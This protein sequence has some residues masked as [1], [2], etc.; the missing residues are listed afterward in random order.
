[1]SNAQ[2]TLIQPIVNLNKLYSY[3][4]NSLNILSHNFKLFSNYCLIQQN[5]NGILSYAYFW[6]NILLL[7]LI[8]KSSFKSVIPFLFVKKATFLNPRHTLSS[9]LKQ[10]KLSYKRN[11]VKTSGT[12]LLSQMYYTYNSQFLLYKQYF[13]NISV[14]LF[15]PF[16]KKKPR[17]FTF[18]SK[19]FSTKL[20]KTKRLRKNIFFHRKF[21][22]LSILTQ[23]NKKFKIFNNNRFNSVRKFLKT[24][25]LKKKQLLKKKHYLTPRQT[26]FLNGRRLNLKNKKA[27]KT[28]LLRRMVKFYRR[29]L[30]R[31]NLMNFHSNSLN[32]NLKYKFKLIKSKKR[33]YQM[34]I[35]SLKSPQFQLSKLNMQRVIR[36]GKSRLK[37]RRTKKY[38]SLFLKT[39][40]TLL[41]QPLFTSLCRYYKISRV[42][43]L[44]R[45][46]RRH[47][48]RYKLHLFPSLFCIPNTS[49]TL[50]STTN[51]MDGNED[52][53]LITN[54]FYS[55]TSSRTYYAL[56]K[57][58]SKLINYSF[59]R[60]F[61]NLF[62][63][64]VNPQ[65]SKN[66]SSLLIQSKYKTPFI[67][68]NVGF[69][70]I[71]AIFI[72]TNSYIKSRLN[73]FRYS[74]FFKKDL[75][76]YLLRKPGKLKLISTSILSTNYRKKN[77]RFN[78]SFV[79]NQFTNKLFG[80]TKTD[81][82]FNLTNLLTSQNPNFSFKHS[83]KYTK[84]LG[85]FFK[86][87]V[88][89]KRI[90]FKPGYA[91]IWRNA[92]ETLNSSLNY[93]VKYQYRLTQRLHK[94]Q[95]LTKQT[96][97]YLHDLILKNVLLNSRFVTDHSTS[98]MFIE[99][100]LVFVNGS[101]SSNPNLNV[102]QND[103][104]QIIVSLKYYIIF[105]WLSNWNSS[106]RIR[107]RKL[108]KTKFKK[109]KIMANKQRSHNL[110]DWILSSRLKSFDIPKYLEVDFFTLS[111]FV[112]YE[113]FVINDFN[114]TNFLESRSEIINM[115]N[116]KYI[117]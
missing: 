61:Q 71:Q 21:W 96:Q 103:F 36:R 81:N 114:S 19:T 17:T 3:N 13:N 72:Q 55:Y 1:M 4:S 94:L 2:S 16:V 37:L 102:F 109:F 101:K 75:K 44:T 52:D 99:S 86:K 51:F 63:N 116:W 34:N 91:R 108:S 12:S 74:F 57:S 27:D 26:L 85:A 29:K 35:L 7:N 97:A 77:K 73:R 48:R 30:R 40:R 76:R 83:N 117:N 38:Y 104:I 58:E 43:Y 88:R 67:L 82:N 60:I 93:N 28:I 56:V 66:G 31:I 32:K 107:L 65:V 89:I 14:P 95:H 22:F 110:P 45:F 5:S 20:L 23:N 90:K 59:Q 39:N 111:S 78:Q 84:Y 49:F 54:Y 6:S 33:N 41:K 87:E 100:N 9:S 11:L 50:A 112:L 79:P 42:R 62:T 69:V 106:K 46:F 80:L 92:R 15:S 115:Y 105:R 64:I 10:V 18:L 25:R 24:M 47:L 53:S 8:S 98:L 68:S 113:P 70:F